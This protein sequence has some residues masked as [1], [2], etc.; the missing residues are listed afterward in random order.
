[1]KV[2]DIFVNVT[3]KLEEL[4]CGARWR[5]LRGLVTLGLAAALNTQELVDGIRLGR[6]LSGTGLGLSSDKFH[7]HQSQAQIEI[8]LTFT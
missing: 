8:H 1:M 3:G 7:V 4:L 2:L 5:L 6:S